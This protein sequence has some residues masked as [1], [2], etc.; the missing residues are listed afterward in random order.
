LARGTGRHREGD[1]RGEYL[2]TA[3]GADVAKAAPWVET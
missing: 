3:N 2:Y 1:E